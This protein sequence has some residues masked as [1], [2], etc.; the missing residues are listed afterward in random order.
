MGCDSSSA[1]IPSE[2]RATGCEGLQ[3]G[4][5]MLNAQRVRS[6]EMQILQILQAFF[7]F[8]TYRFF[9]GRNVAILYQSTDDDANQ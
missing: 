5:A 1:L 4:N 2:T 7:S 8:S 9:K 3:D 6:S